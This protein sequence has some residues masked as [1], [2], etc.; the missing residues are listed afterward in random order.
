[1]TATRFKESDKG[2]KV[3]AGDNFEDF[4][5]YLFVKIA[6]EQLFNMRSII[7]SGSVGVLRNRSP[8]RIA[9][10]LVLPTKKSR[11]MRYTGS[12]RSWSKMTHSILLISLPDVYA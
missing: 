2:V 8:G 9:L 12:S 4:T 3:G 7:R 11:P 5:K 1:M 10:P 6:D